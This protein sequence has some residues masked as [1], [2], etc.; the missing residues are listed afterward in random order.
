MNNNNNNNNNGRKEKKN[1]ITGIYYLTLH[2]HINSNVYL[3]TSIFCV[4]MLFKSYLASK[5]KVAA[6]CNQKH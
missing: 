2:S 3:V 1:A 6:G 5:T 4:S